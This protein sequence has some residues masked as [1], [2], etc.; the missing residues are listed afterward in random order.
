MDPIYRIDPS[1]EVPIYQQLVD[2]IAADIRKG[3]LADGRKL[4]TV[5]A[6]SQELTIARGTIKRA[7]DELEL[8][9][10]VEKVQGRGT[11]VRFQS[12]DS[13]SRKDLAMAAIDEMLQKLETMGFSPAEIHI[14]LNLK[15]RS[16]AERETSV[17]VAVVADCREHLE[18]MAAQLRPLEGVEVFSFLLEQV[19]RYP[20]QLGEDKDLV[21][22]APEHR[23]YLKS[24]LPPKQRIAQVALRPREEGLRGILSLVP[25]TRVGIA[26]ES[27]AFAG[28]LSRLLCACRK[29]VA[30]AAPFW[31]PD[32]E[33]LAEYAKDLDALLLPEG[34][35]GLL[36]GA[37]AALGTFGGTLV[38]CGFQMDDGSM[39]YLTAKIKGILDAKSV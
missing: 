38:P 36:S 14:F 2:A 26:A 19:R 23:E 16:W 17:Q 6:L 21:V 37:R 34:Y 31:S 25:G 8:R 3:V 13:A 9:G 11:F 7:Y 20:Y 32:G 4:P 15:L 18:A 12:A 28:A 35:E 1:L 30:A 27:E 24:V 5:Q 33:A 29:D 10:L 22:C 39:L